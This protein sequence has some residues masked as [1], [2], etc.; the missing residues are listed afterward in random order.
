MVSSGAGFYKP[1][2]KTATVM[3]NM[4][5]ENTSRVGYFEG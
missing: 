1:E 5:Q 2:P 3:R 4:G